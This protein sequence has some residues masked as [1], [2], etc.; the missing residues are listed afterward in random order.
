[1]TWSEDVFYPAFKRAGMLKLATVLHAGDSE[2]AEAWVDFCKPDSLAITGV[3]S[4]DYE[5]EFEVADFP[6]LDEGDQV[7]IDS[8]KYLVRQVPRVEGEQA[9]G[10]WKKALL[11]KA[12]A[13]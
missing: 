8:E 4:S 12:A 6:N 13:C 1:V 9:T 11:T 5:M 2:T 3:Q 7:V 10:R